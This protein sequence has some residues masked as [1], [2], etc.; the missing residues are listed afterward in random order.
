MLW[1]HTLFLFHNFMLM[2]LKFL[3]FIIFYC[4]FWMFILLK[5]GQR[6]PLYINFHQLLLITWSISLSALPC[7]TRHL[8][9]AS[10]FPRLELSHFFKGSSLCSEGMVFKNQDLGLVLIASFHVHFDA[11]LS[12]LRRME[13]RYLALQAHWDNP[14]ILLRSLSIVNSEH[15]F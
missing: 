6:D 2:K 10:Y 4:H 9:M 5:F 11:A 1:L 14:F 12:L 8:W 15:C 13:R 3:M 7:P